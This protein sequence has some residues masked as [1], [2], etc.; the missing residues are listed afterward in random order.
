MN[1]SFFRHSGDFIVIQNKIKFYAMDTKGR[2]TKFYNPEELLSN[3]DLYNSLLLSGFNEI[4]KFLNV[5]RPE[6]IPISKEEILAYRD[7]EIA[8]EKKWDDY[9]QFPI[10][11]A[12]KLT[13]SDI[14]SFYQL[15]IY[16]YIYI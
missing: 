11:I 3:N 12:K 4:Y 5:D 15:Y 14:N 2:I 8:K 6:Y 13:P 1:I 10:I 7:N 16:M 9:K